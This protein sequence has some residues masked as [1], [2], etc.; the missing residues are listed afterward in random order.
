MKEQIKIEDNGWI[1]VSENMNDER[2]WMRWHISVFH[3]G[4]QK[5]QGYRGTPVTSKNFQKFIDSE[6]ALLRTIEKNSK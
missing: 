1:V 2:I 6:K 4:E 3:N 5:S